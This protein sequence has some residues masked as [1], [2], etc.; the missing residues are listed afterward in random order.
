MMN[1]EFIRMVL[2]S[3]SRRKKS[4]WKVGVITFL[5]IFLF[6]GI[7]IFQDCMNQFVRENAFLES[8]EWLVSTVGRS[9]CLEEHAWVDGYGTTVVR[10]EIYHRPKDENM[11]KARV[12]GLV[13]YV[14]EGFLQLSNLVI[15]SGRMPKQADEIT[16][17]QHV[18]SDMGYRYELGQML[19]LAYVKGY[20]ELGE[21]IYGFVEYK[22]VGILENYTADWAV[23]EELPEFFVTEGG[24]KSIQDV[25]QED[26][27]RVYYYL[28]H[29]Q[30][31]INGEGF[32][33]TMERVLRKQGEDHLLFGMIYNENAYGV[34]MWGSQDLYLVMMSLCAI[35]GSM[36]LIYLFLMCCNH[37]RPYYFKLREL[38]AG[39]GQVRGMICLEWCGIFLPSAF[40]GMM[41]A[42]IFSCLV[43]ATISK[44]FKIPFIFRLTGNSVFLILLFTVGVF[45][46]VLFWSC[47]LFRITNLYQMTGVL[48]VRRLKKMYRKG[49]REKN[50][51]SLFQIRKKRAEPGKNLAQILFIMATM[52]I[53]LYSLWTI[54]SAYRN[55]QK[56]EARADLFASLRGEGEFKAS[57]G[58]N[59]DEEEHQLGSNQ[60]GT[61]NV[62]TK[63][64]SVDNGISE[65][66]VRRLRLAPGVK[67][68]CGI[69]TDDRIGLVWSG[70]QESG[71]LRD[72]FIK[73]WV[74][75]DM[76]TVANFMY[77]SEGYPEWEEEWHSLYNQVFA[78][79]P[80]PSQH[81]EYY[82][83][84]VVGMAR[85]EERDLLL[86]KMFGSDFHSKDFWS[87]KQS[88]L[89]QI[90]SNT[91][92]SFVFEDTPYN[93][94]YRKP[95]QGI[96]KKNG[97]NEQYF[98]GK[99][100]EEYRYRF[101][102]NTL[103]TGDLLQIQHALLPGGKIIETE[104]IYCDELKKYYQLMQDPVIS[105]NYE[106]PYDLGGGM[107]GQEGGMQ[108]LASEKLLKQ[109]A[110]ASGMEFTYRTILIDVEHGSDRKQV[111]AN[112]ADLLSRN[113]GK[114]ISFG[115]YMGEKQRER[116]R[117]YRQLVMFGV[118]LLLTGSVYLFITRSMQNKYFALNRK[119]LQQ[120]LH[121]GCS[122]EELLRSFS[123]LR[124]RES[125]WALAGI[126]LCMFILLAARGFSYWKEVQGG[127]M[128]FEWAELW[129]E[130]GNTII[131][132]FNNPLGWCL[133]LIFLGLTVGIG[134]L[135]QKRFLWQLELMGKE[136][137]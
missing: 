2:L 86:K 26:Q 76:K 132:Y 56:S 20:N 47:L 79:I 70:M 5:C 15:Y 130:L 78:E 88:V 38:G 133:F 120:F 92:Y 71:F 42:G 3:V 94:P 7:M 98:H 122:R 126:P 68:V 39:A 10:T 113:Q 44:H 69:A 27:Q 11:N 31:N 55:Y 90:Q 77:N 111:E 65:D 119:Q 118:I 99:W 57:T 53:A 28:N 63:G 67:R 41:I 52:T 49:D 62:I 80:D 18:L 33:R 101:E 6:T 35:L 16:V 117:F 82:A 100:G 106:L 64:D 48:P 87:G 32:Y 85:T 93:S 37:R 59:W 23:P 112:V 17:T 136:E 114:E 125:I 128:E 30:R 73:E 116:N 137:E 46:L 13:G 66:L 107:D 19:S 50:P 29:K 121:C 61:D 129:K 45:I 25:E 108:L 105:S 134:I 84:S 115:S 9:K 1:L 58:I 34:T 124:I 97:Q 131:D 83:E 91:E 40:A 22:L 103:K 110:S 95:L 36:S 12:E 8:G 102:E 43:A 109:F 72:L 104:V 21:P 74:E 89:F 14:D 123:F 96:L 4:M 60:I 135:G 81:P 127:D 54:R 51:V 75:Q 24:L